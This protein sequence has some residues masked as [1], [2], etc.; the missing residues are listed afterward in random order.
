MFEGIT[1][2]LFWYSHMELD[3]YRQKEWVHPPL[4]IWMMTLHGTGTLVVKNGA[5]AVRPII[6]I[7]LCALFAKTLY[8]WL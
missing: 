7:V 6:L 4:M 3:P 2:R 1:S 5:A 8:G